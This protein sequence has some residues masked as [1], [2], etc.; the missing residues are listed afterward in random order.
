MVAALGALGDVQK[1]YEDVFAGDD[2]GA[3]CRCRR[4]TPSPGQDDSTYVKHPPYF[5]GMGAG[6][7][8]AAA[9]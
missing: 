8:A 6:A 4:A 2:T 7:G 3:R 5:Q 9:T 1:E